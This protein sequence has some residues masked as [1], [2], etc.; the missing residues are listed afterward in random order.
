MRVIRYLISLLVLI[1][2]L[3]AAS[4]TTFLNVLPTSPEE[5]H[6]DSKV[7]EVLKQGTYNI[8]CVG[9]DKGQTNA[10]TI[11]LIS[12]DS[13]KKTVNLLSIPRDTM[14]NT[15][16]F[17]KKIN[18]SYGEGGI[19]KTIE[20]V[21]MLTDIDIDRYIITSFEGFE[22]VIDAFGGL[23]MN[24]PAP[25]S[26]Q[27]THQ[28]L[29]INLPAGEQ[30][31]DGKSALQFVRFRYGYNTG[32]IGRIGAQQLFFK[33]LAEKVTSTNVIKALPEITR[34]INKDMTTNLSIQ[35]M[36]WFAKEGLKVNLSNDVH[37]F[38]L[39]GSSQ[40]VDGLSY[41]IP[42]KQG[43]LNMLRKH[44]IT[45]ESLPTEPGN[46]Q[47]NTV[48]VPEKEINLNLVPQAEYTTQD[49]LT[50]GDKPTPKDANNT[51]LEPEH[52]YNPYQ[53]TPKAEV[54]PPQTQPA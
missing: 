35:E 38:L 23:D 29:Y 8:L 31:L 2:L 41:Y 52:S 24:L 45:Q 19:E 33:A 44:F 13:I 10:D 51:P 40:F 34:T 14:S 37:M 9:I 25:L 3:S 4:V 11:I 21:K 50:E 43:I 17:V 30:H 7:N 47:E 20:E 28:D 12:F 32:D 48:P 42:S 5:S 53:P 27:D 1:C 22:K 16:R 39:P 54:P 36:F 49:F 18:A 6:A 46:T 26:Y 15:N